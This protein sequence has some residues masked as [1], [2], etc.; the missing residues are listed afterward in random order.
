MIDLRPDLQAAIVALCARCPGV[1]RVWLFGSRAR[2]D[3][4][5]VSDID[6]AI[7]APNATAADWLDLRFRLAE[8]LPTLVL[9]DVVRWEQAPERLRQRILAEGVVLHDAARPAA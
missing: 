1:G 4:T 6:L 8:D 3:G 7:E 9:V 2:G 5:R